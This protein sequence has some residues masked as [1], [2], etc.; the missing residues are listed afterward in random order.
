MNNNRMKETNENNNM[1]Q[2]AGIEFCTMCPSQCPKDALSCGRGR[3]FFQ[4]GQEEG[5]A[6]NGQ[7][8]DGG[9]HEN[10]ES[11]REHGG[12]GHSGERGGHG[13]HVVAGEGR[14]CG[15]YKHSGE[16]R[17]HGRHEYSEECGK[18]G[19]HE[20]RGEHRGHEEHENYETNM[21]DLGSLMRTCGHFLYHSA[22]EKNGQGRIM[23]ILS[24]KES[25]SQKELQEQ[26]GIQ[27][28]SMSE[29][30]AKME[31]KGLIQR[32]KDE[33]D[34]RKTNVCITEAGKLHVQ[35]YRKNKGKQDKFAALNEEQKEQL[36]ELLSILLESWK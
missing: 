12:H 18:R 26:L 8:G 4:E 9:H 15:R 30:L 22:G 13:R 23:H 35:E 33:D 1:N 2:P 28:G 27:P 19:R 24:G 16:E 17:G 25:I 20:N 36:K 31:V 14:G 29:I 21:D 6:Q 11:G 3:R 32:Q 7:E 10:Y 5:T 34:K